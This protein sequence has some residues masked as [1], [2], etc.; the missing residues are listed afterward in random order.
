VEFEEL[1]P[2]NPV[3]VTPYVTAGVGQENKLNEQESGYEMHSTFKK[4]AGL[5][6]KYSLTNNLTADLTINTDFAQVEPD[7]EVICLT[8]KQTTSARSHVYRKTGE[9]KR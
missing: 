5:D 7:I 1:K 3:Y 2:Q 4:D 9:T 6:V 8:R